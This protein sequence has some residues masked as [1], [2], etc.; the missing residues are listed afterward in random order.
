MASDYAAYR[1]G[2]PDAAV[3]YALGGRTGHVLDLGAGTGKLTAALVG[4]AS[5]VTAVDPDPAMLAE[6]RRLLPAV[7]TFEAGAE[8]IPL[9]DGSVEAVV[10]GQSFHWFATT[11][12]MTEIARVLAP[13]GVLAALWNADD[14]RVDWV[15]Q[16]QK[17]ASRDRPVPGVPGGDDRY[18]PAHPDFTP[19]ERGDFAHSQRL[20]VEG[21]LAV[22]GTHSWALVSE[23]TDRDAVYER[24]RRHLAAR[25]EIAHGA[26]DLPILTTVRTAQRR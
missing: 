13:G 11:A 14:T 25:P 8:A 4:R 26:F 9:P 6:L 20:T 19:G 15:A 10:C 23:P 2:Y 22:L 16:Y 1:P 12:A 18:L 24:V 17:V 3:D 5:T 7:A 21:L